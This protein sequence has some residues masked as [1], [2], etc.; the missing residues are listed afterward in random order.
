MGK[1]EVPVMD[2]LD[3]I[4][5]C[6]CLPSA[7]ETTPFGPEV[8]VYKVGGKMFA[9]TVPEE[10]PPRINLKCDPERSLELRD[11]HPGVLPGWHMNKRHWNTVMLDEVPTVLVKEL[12][13]HSYY[14]V[15][16]SL[17][18]RLRAELTSK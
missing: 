17:P 3:V 15:V 6:L 9:A 8:L 5:M 1:V 4:E 18:K 14:L 10:H 12:V 2:L 13:K 16:A 11:E 7:E